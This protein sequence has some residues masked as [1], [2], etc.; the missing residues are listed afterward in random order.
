M[1]VRNLYSEVAKELGISRDRVS[2]IYS[3]YWNCIRDGLKALDLHDG[4]DKGDFEGKKYGFYIQKVG[5]LYCDYPTYRARNRK[6]MRIKEKRN[7]E[8]NKHQADVQ[9]HSDNG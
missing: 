9:S 7:A 3:A 4:M 2:M 8:D 1:R 5:R 6:L